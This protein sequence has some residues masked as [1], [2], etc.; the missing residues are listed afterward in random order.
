MLDGAL[1]L[2]GLGPVLRIINDNESAERERQRR[3]E[4]LGFGARAGP[5]RGD[6]LE[7]GTELEP[8][9]DNRCL[10]VVRLDDEFDVELLRRR[11]RAAS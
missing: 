6:D 10:D 4:R 11:A 3:V 7:R 2:V 9:Q 1:Q 5:G 8:R